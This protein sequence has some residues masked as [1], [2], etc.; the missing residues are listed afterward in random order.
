VLVRSNGILNS[1][2]SSYI[3]SEYRAINISNSIGNTIGTH[4]TGGTTANVIYAANI[5]ITGSNNS[6]I[7]MTDLIVH[8]K[9]NNSYGVYSLAGSYLYFI[10]STIAITSGATGTTGLAAVN[11]SI[12]QTASINNTQVAT[13]KTP[14]AATD[15]A[16]IT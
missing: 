8:I 10:Y 4:S 7:L 6:G 5:A 12:L 1:V 15:P 14:A 9:N 11:G 16:Y 2:N 13:A 3:G